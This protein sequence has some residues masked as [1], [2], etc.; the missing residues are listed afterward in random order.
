[1]GNA[2]TSPIVKVYFGDKEVV[3][4]KFGTSVIYDKENEQAEQT[5][6]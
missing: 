4:I 3:K 6:E 5:E 2:G 1:M